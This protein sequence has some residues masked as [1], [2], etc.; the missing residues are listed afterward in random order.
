VLDHGLLE[1]RA[2]LLGVLDNLVA[3]GWLVTTSM[4]RRWLDADV[5]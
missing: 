5:A 1:G 2:E 3:Y 4:G